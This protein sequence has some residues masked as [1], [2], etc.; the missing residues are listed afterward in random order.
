MPYRRSHRSRREAYW[1]VGA[2]AVVVLLGVALLVMANRHDD[3]DDGSERDRTAQDATTDR[4]MRDHERRRKTRPSRSEAPPGWLS[5]AAGTG[6]YDDT[7]RHAV[8]TATT[9]SGS[10][11]GVKYAFSTGAGYRDGKASSTTGSWRAEETV[12]GFEPLAGLVAQVVD[13]TVTCTATIDGRV[14]SRS[15]NSGRFATVVCAA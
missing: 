3:P 15:T 12:R 14:V 4:K 1:A 2:V 9:S 6:G 10:L 8:L 11:L 13:G 7:P 5:Q